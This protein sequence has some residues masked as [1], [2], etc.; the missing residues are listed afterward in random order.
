ML[1]STNSLLKSTNSLFKTTNSLLKSINTLLKCTNSILE[2]YNPSNPL[3]ECSN[4][5]Y[6]VLASFNPILEWLNP[7]NPI[8]ECPSTSNPILVS[9]N[10]SNPILKYYNPILVSSNPFNP[11]LDSY[12]PILVSSDP[13]SCAWL[14]SPGTSRRF[15]ESSNGSHLTLPYTIR[16]WFLHVNIVQYTVG[17]KTLWNIILSGSIK[18][19]IM[20]GKS[21]CGSVNTRRMSKLDM[22]SIFYIKN[23]WNILNIGNYYVNYE[24][25]QNKMLLTSSDTKRTN[26]AQRELVSLCTQSVH[27][28]N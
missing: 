22:G 5:S 17:T 9:S 8:L 27:N 14:V 6:P 3:L 4:S 19:V 7:S 26:S 15:I 20:Q 2:C 11:K 23:Q 21:L 13:Y 16:N 1:K 10:P 25:Y 24:N 28:C 12:N 18:V